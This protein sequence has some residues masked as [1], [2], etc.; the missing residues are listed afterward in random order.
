MPELSSPLIVRP[1]EEADIPAL[2]ELFERAYPLLSEADEPWTPAHLSSHLAVFP[3]GQLVAEM[4][5]QIVGAAGSLIVH[6]GRDPLRH[7]TYYGITDDGWFTNHSLEGDTLYGTDIYVDPQRRGEGIAGALYAE[8]RALCQRLNLRRILAGGRIP[9]YR[10]LAAEMGAD[11]YAQRVDSGELND[12]VLSFQ[13]A[14]GFVLRGVMPHYIRDPRSLDHAALIEWLNPEYHPEQK[15]DI[16]LRVCAVQYQ[17]RRIR[18]FEEFADQVE[19]FVDTAADYK[20]DI[21]LFP[22]FLTVQL[23]SHLDPLSSQEGIRKVATFTE[24]YIALFQRLAREYG[25]DI[26]A[27]TH[28][29]LDEDGQLRNKAFYFRQNGSH[30]AQ[31]KLHITPS[32]REW[33]GIT[34][35]HEL[36]IIQTTKARIGILICYDVE[37]PEATRYLAEQGIEILFVP[38]CTD[39]R[40]GHLRVSNCARARAI[41]N[42]IFVVTAGMT[43]N[44]PSVP[45]MD[46]HYGQAAVYTPSDFEFARDG[47]QAIADPNI[48]TM[49]VADLNIAELYHSRASGSVTLVQDRRLDLFPAKTALVAEAMGDGI[50]RASL[51]ETDSWP[52]DA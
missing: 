18:S 43:G 3:Q 24:E 31:P 42:Q 5:G 12:P 47:I 9:G 11:E 38:Y 28:P 6:L 46:I 1:A 45:V 15:V 50:L 29:V 4:D 20:A 44:L 19:Y 37:F 40:H 7:H 21:V 51:P 33:W 32:E 16:P 25:V 36:F 17:M 23:L 14:Q 39:T 35:G 8:R 27:G 49:I 48:E 26:I 34:G 2:I 52:G 41:E 22:E 13:L 30:V 10:P